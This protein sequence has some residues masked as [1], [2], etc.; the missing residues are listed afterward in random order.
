VKYLR[1][2]L[3]AV[4]VPITALIL[5]TAVAT[6]YGVKLGFDVRGTPDQ[7][8]IAQFAQQVG[9]GW[10]TALQVL[11]TLP[12]AMWASRTFTARAPKYGAAVG[13]LVAAIEL[14]VVSALSLEMMLGAALSI[15]AGWLGGVM[16]ASRVSGGEQRG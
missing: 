7:G 4:A 2:V 1:I 10:W 8:K 14:V 3:A 11:L 6:A 13:V 9:R 15:G 16:A 12:F 5:I